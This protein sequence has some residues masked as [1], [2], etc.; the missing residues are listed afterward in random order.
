MA[1]NKVRAT[2]AGANPVNIR[3]KLGRLEIRLQFF[4]IRVIKSWNKI[5]AKVKSVQKMRYL[6]ANRQTAERRPVAP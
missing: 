1:E 5:P 4:S 3:V 6:S 2:G